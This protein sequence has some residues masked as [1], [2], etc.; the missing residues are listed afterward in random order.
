MRAVSRVKQTHIAKKA[1]VHHAWQDNAL[2]HYSISYALLN[3]CSVLVSATPPHWEMT[4]NEK[5][6]TGA[7]RSA[8]Q[9]SRGEGAHDR[10]APVRRPPQNVREAF[11]PNHVLPFA[12]QSRQVRNGDVFPCVH[13][14]SSIRVLERKLGLAK[15][16]PSCRLC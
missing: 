1:G 12:K 8:I 16:L 10:Y 7:H 15:P 13:E 6:F 3:V 4:R 14:L 2:L 11:V 9:A 5:D